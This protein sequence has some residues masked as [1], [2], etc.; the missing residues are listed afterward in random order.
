M[1]T[2]LIPGEYLLSRFPDDPRARYS[3]A[4]VSF[5]QSTCCDKD[6]PGRSV[7]MSN[8][9]GE[10][11]AVMK[12]GS[13]PN[14]VPHTSHI[15][16]RRRAPPLPPLLL[17]YFPEKVCILLLLTRSQLLL[18]PPAAPRSPCGSLLCALGRLNCSPAK[19]RANTQR[20]FMCAQSGAPDVSF[21]HQ[22]PRRSFCSH[23]WTDGAGTRRLISDVASLLL[24]SGMDSERD[25]SDGDGVTQSSR[26]HP[27]G[28]YRSIADY[29]FFFSKSSEN[30]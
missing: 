8:N 9:G 17:A 6:K 23:L 18:R 24:S 21:P 16:P 3:A 2:V 1:E 30:W 14:S 5:L 27:A 28:F 22:A 20:V 10:G 26:L 4:G 11:G 12:V 15:H 29:F 7:K 25:G 13:C 19:R